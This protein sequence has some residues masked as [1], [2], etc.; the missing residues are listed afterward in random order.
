MMLDSGATAFVPKGL[1]PHDLLDRLGAIIGR[2]ITIDRLTDSE[3]A[4]PNGAAARPR[5]ARSRFR[6][7]ILER[8]P[9]T[10]DFIAL[11]LQSCDIDVV[12]ES[13][14]PARALAVVDLAQP[15]LV[16]LDLSQ[17]DP[18]DMT[19]ITDVGR[20]TSRS[21]VIVYSSYEVRRIEA[22]EAGA[23]AF[24]AKPLIDELTDRIRQLIPGP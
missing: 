14:T 4:K 7:V 24:I 5:R 6:A 8:D 3:Q 2:S 1:A 22:L 15:E 17:D 20:Q 12:A 13:G 9:V 11:A 21:V 10:R 16:V 23:V 19:I 18:T